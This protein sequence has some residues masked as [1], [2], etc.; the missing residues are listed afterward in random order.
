MLP[1]T[2]SVTSSHGYFQG[3]GGRE[4]ARGEAAGVVHPDALGWPQSAH[5]CSLPTSPASSPTLRAVTW[6]CL[7]VT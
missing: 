5:L 3:P 1:G 7:S 2:K 4:A 6:N